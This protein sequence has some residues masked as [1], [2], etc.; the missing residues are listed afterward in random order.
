MNYRVYVEVL[1]RN[2]T[3][4]NQ[5]YPFEY[6]TV[7]PTEYIY[8]GGDYISYINTTL[9]PTCSPIPI[10]VPSREPVSSDNKTT[11]SGIAP[12]RIYY[13]KDNIIYGITISTGVVF[14]CMV[15]VYF[16][17]LFKKNHA[18]IKK[19]QNWKNPTMPKYIKTPE[20]TNYYPEME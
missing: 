20:H 17:N 16:Y 9:R 14:V 13:T 10:K 2:L 3:V 1:P 4:Y 5:T 12:H 19:I 11:Q 15:F 18:K 6:D 7:E 8:D